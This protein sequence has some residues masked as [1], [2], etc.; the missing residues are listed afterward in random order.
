MANIMKTLREEG[1][2]EICGVKVVESIDYLNDT[3]KTAEGTKGTGLPK[4][5]VLKYVL[6]DDTWVA[7]RPS[8]TEPKLKFY[9]GVKSDTEE[10]ATK[11]LA[12]FAKEIEGWE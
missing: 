9:V 8:G 4:A 3:D 7:A 11:K 5:N 1:I 10:G 6:A 2:D 12:D